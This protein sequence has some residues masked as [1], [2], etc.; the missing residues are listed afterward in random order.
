[1]PETTQADTA[2]SIAPEDQARA[3]F[4]AL[5]ARLYGSAPD[6]AVLSAIAACDE[7]TADESSAAGQALAES[8]RK[9]IGASAAMDAGAAADEYQNLFVGVGRSEVS[10]HESAYVKSPGRSPLIEIRAMLAKLGLAR[11]SGVNIYEDHLAAVFET[12]RALITGAGRGEP[13]AFA[14]QREFFEAHVGPWVGDCC[15]AIQNSP[16]ANYYRRVA[17]FTQLFMVIE[18][19]SFAIE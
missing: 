8:W 18:R 17:E 11:Q 1:M 13:F 7:L 15:I 2:F 9:L 16:V 6:A 12:L 3:D 4:Y 5:L 14:E 19:D 10:I